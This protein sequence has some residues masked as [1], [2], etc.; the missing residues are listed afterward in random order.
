MIDMRS[1][2][3]TR[4][5]PEMRQAMATAPVGDDVLGD[6]QLVN[7]LQAM[8]AERLGKEA[9]LFVPS[10]MMGNLLGVRLYAGH[11]LS[12]VCDPR[13]HL[14]Q[15]AVPA[16]NGANM[17]P[18]MGDKFG[19]VPL[20]ALDAALAMDAFGHKAALLCLED[21]FNQV[22]GTALKAAYIEKAAGLAHARGIP[23]HLDGARLFNA[24]IALGVDAAELAK[25]ADTV[26]F[27]ISKGL[28]APVGSLLVGR[29]ELIAEAAHQRHLC[30]GAMRQV[31]MLAACGIIALE[32]MV[33]R[34]AED[35]ANARMLAEGL[36][37]IEE[38]EIDLEV[39]Q[40]NLIYFD[41]RRL[42]VTG[43]AC[44]AALTQAGLGN[45]AAGPTQIRLVTHKDVSRQDCVEALA[46]VKKTVKAYRN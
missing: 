7:R 25:P 24:A 14:A 1:D 46:I 5:T 15:C 27:C 20:D 12:V 45:F 22:G 44:E 40:T 6:D 17:T 35:N 4:P 39:L 13:Q 43:A 30:G 36:A 29:R 9:G 31:G 33:D 28:G 34:L 2:G 41:V 19:Y 18:V 26:M 32:K 16:T 38:L 23:V 3:V 21:S 8:A 42:G 11:G 37:Q 10:G